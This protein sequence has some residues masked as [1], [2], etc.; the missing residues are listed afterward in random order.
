M[1]LLT[2]PLPTRGILPNYPDSQ[3][4]DGYAAEMQDMILDNGTLMTRGP[5]GLSTNVSYQGSV[6]MRG[7]MVHERVS[8]GSWTLAVQGSDGVLYYIAQSGGAFGA[9][10]SGSTATGVMFRDHT[11]FSTKETAYTYATTST[12][13]SDCVTRFWSGGSKSDYTTGTI[14]TTLNS[15]AVTGSGTS[16]TANVEA[17]MYLYSQD[18]Y[19]GRVSNVVS[20]TSI[21]LDAPARVVT[22]GANYNI[23][24]L[25]PVANIYATGAVTVA[26]GATVV[27]GA[28]TAWKGL[29]DTLTWTL[30]RLRDG[31]VIGTVSTFNT[32]GSITLT[33]GANAAMNNE[34]YFLAGQGTNTT[35]SAATTE[36]YAGRAWWG[37]LASAGPYRNIE[38][39]DMTLV[40]SSTNHY[41]S[42][43]LAFKIPPGRQ[44]DRIQ[45][46]FNVT[47]GLLV[48]CRFGAWLVTGR[49]AAT[50]D[51]VKLQEDGVRNARAADANGSSAAWAGE[52]GI[53]HFSGGQLQ[54]LTRTDTGSWADGKFNTG[55]FTFLTYAWRF[56][57]VNFGDGNTPV[58]EPAYVFDTQNN[59][60]SRWL[61]AHFRGVA[62]YGAA[63]STN[64]I[65]V[66]GGSNGSRAFWCTYSDLFD[67]I[68]END[69]VSAYAS[70]QYGP[71]PILETKEYDAGNFY[72]EKMFKDI[73]LDYGRGTA[74]ANAPVVTGYLYGPSS[75]GT[76][77]TLGTAATR[78]VQT[79]PVNKRGRR[80][81]IR[82]ASP[83]LTSATARVSI[84][85][86]NLGVRVRNM[87]DERSRG[88]SA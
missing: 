63:S 2:L 51:V 5:I 6:D 24:S 82:I 60:W 44:G 54:D 33:G 46:I 74:T 59:L 25:R 40:A 79:I 53:Y 66:I 19:V 56:I 45:R 84:I 30:F 21:T 20:N 85:L 71:C 47:D 86:Y 43:E 67:D 32:D 15:A 28:G 49:T 65:S 17:G 36:L 55:K 41:E 77:T 3:L 81:K 76:A 31:F 75:N 68:F 18:I 4:P 7:F 42:I 13:T 27:V 48:L 12:N 8:G 88:T 23:S 38:V 73:V 11:P 16:W 70:S 10:T 14:T 39:S 64:R 22:A 9:S 57:I 37:G 80:F 72:A 78:E 58:S 29:N 1:E 34:P 62:N 52:R 26:S 87:N 50:F 61:G 69:G 83:T 35:L